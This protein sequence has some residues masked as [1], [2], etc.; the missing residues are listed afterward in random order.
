MQIETSDEF[1][2]A[3]RALYLRNDSRGAVVASVGIDPSGDAPAVWLN[4]GRFSFRRRIPF[5]GLRGQYRFP[6]R[7]RWFLRGKLALL[8]RRYR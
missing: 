6:R 3:W 4:V 7:L 2:C 5:V 8:D 1:T